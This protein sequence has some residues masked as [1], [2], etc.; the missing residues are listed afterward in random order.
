M[1]SLVEDETPSS[2]CTERAKRCII[3]IDRKKREDETVSSSFAGKKREH[4]TAAL[5]FSTSAFFKR[6]V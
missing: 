5:S 2:V 6:T 4:I 3:K 1:K